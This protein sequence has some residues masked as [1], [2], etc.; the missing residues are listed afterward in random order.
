MK[1]IIYTIYAV[2]VLLFSGFARANTVG[3]GFGLHNQPALSFATIYDVTVSQTLDLHV[4]GYVPT[5]CHSEPAGI[6][7][8]DPAN[9]QVLTVQLVTAPPTSMACM[10]RIKEFSAV[11]PLRQLVRTSGLMLEDEATYI[12]KTG[13]YE[14]AFQVSGSDLKN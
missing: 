3:L 7:V 11:I 4:T 2:T 5:Q 1:F 10:F 9:P 8:Q 6:L 12:V 14:F 13:G